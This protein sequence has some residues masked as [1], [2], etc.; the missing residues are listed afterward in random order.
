MNPLIVIPAR[1][2]STRLPNKPLAEIAGTPMIVHM[3]MRAKESAVGAALVACD[4][5]AIAA[6]VRAAG[7]TAILTDPNHPSGSDRIWEAVTRY[8]P[9]GTYDIIINLQGDV[10][11]LEPHLLADVLRPLA[12]PA[13]DI[14]TLI[15]TIT[16]PAEIT[17][18]S[19]VKAYGSF[20]SGHARATNFSRQPI[21]SPPYYHHIGVYAYRRAALERFVSLPPSA[22]EQS[23]RLEQLRAL[24]NGMRIDAVL[25]DTVPLGVDTPEDLERARKLLCNV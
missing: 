18:P 2:A 8:D 17:S 7:G 4:G 6:V 13:V 12:D 11:T 25:V 14:A 19:V 20:S 21:G 10:P 1:L 9:A 15:A 23:E 3:L 16:D 24:D 22:R 5:E